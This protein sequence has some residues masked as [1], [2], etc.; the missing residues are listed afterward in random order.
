MKDKYITRQRLVWARIGWAIFE[1]VLLKPLKLSAITNFTTNIFTNLQNLT[2]MFELFSKLVHLPLFQII[3]TYTIIFDFQLLQ[4]LF[5][6][7]LL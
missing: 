4:N 5:E 3:A 2:H 7:L 6:V 1:I